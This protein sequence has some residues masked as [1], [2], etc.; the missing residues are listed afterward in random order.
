MLRRSHA[1]KK[2]IQSMNEYNE[3][4]RRKGH[5]TNSKNMAERCRRRFREDGY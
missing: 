4:I 3:Y 5:K 2:T 1:E